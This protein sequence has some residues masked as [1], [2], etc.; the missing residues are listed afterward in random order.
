MVANNSTWK[1][2]IALGTSVSMLLIS[3]SGA[4]FA[5]SLLT[6]TQADQIAQ[7]SLPG[8]Q[9]LHQSLDTYHGVPVWDIHLTDNGKV[10][11]VKVNR[12]NGAILVKRISNEQ[13]K[14]VSKGNNS[15]SDGSQ[16]ST[17][18]KITSPVLSGNM[19]YDVK[20]TKV[21]AAYQTYVTQA[22]QKVKGTFMWAEFSRSDNGNLEMSIKI[23][24]SS[25]NTVKVKNVFY[26]NSKH[27]LSSKVSADN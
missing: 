14:S 20:L 27:L 12:S 17:S 23:R 15:V 18:E 19:A 11:E 21:P 2:K 1:K 7:K 6:S 3:L 5:Q 9:V 26:G 13:T 10:W 22:L 8:S 25:G 16:T 4:A 24:Q